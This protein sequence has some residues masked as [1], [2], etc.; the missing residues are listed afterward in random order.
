M[1]EF[2]AECGHTVRARDEDA[3]GLVRCSYCGRPANVPDNVGDDLDFLFSEVDQTADAGE[4]SGRRKRGARAAKRR[5]RSGEF[6][7]FAVVL[8][9]CY[10]ALLISIVVVVGRKFVIPLFKDG[11][12]GRV[13]AIPRPEPESRP[14]RRPKRDEEKAPPA[15]QPGLI[16]REKLVG[17]FVDS[18]PAGADVF[19]LEKAK[20]PDGGRINKVQGCGQF[21]SGDGIPHLHDG[22][23]VVEVVFLWSD[24][25]LTEFRGYHD[26]RRALGSAA[27]AERAEL[28]EDYFLPDEGNLF[29]DETAEQIFLVRQYRNVEVINRKSKGVRALFLPRI[30]ESDGESFSVEYL[31]ANHIPRTKSYAF[32]DQNVRDELI[33]YDVK[34]SDVPFVTEALAR[35]GVIPYVTP[36]GYTRL[37]KIDLHDGSFAVRTVRK[38]EQ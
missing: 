24:P 32:D 34:D 35:I 4:S 17:L 19:C 26:F 29:V 30:L 13:S 7:P 31:I 33:F 8:R 23:Y 18:T 5:R 37:F 10:A 6:N 16:A 9:L 38:P 15:N 14:D 1:I 27:G 36:D 3:G 28:I 11:V 20:A 12:E 21:R 2:K 25:Q 22:A